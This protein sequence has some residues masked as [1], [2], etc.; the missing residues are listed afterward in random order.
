MTEPTTILPAVP[1]RYER[2]DKI[3]YA[4][5]EPGLATLTVLSLSASAYDAL[6]GTGLPVPPR[7]AL[8]VLWAGT[9]AVHVGE[10]AYAYRLAKDAGM[11]IT[12]PR[13]AAETF[14]VGFPSLLKLRS[15]IAAG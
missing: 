10:A 8:Q 11:H 5:L 2:P 1:D 13:W 3:W 14:A 7:R 6:K 9:A 15:I 4:L 12:A